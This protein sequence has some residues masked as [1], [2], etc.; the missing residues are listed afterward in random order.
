MDGLESNGYIR[1]IIYGKMSDRNYDGIHLRG[2]HAVRHVSYRTVQAIRNIAVEVK[3][4]DNKRKNAKN[5]DFHRSCPQAEHQRQKLLTNHRAAKSKSGDTVRNIEGQHTK[6][7]GQSQSSAQEVRY[8]DVVR[9]QY[10]YSVPT[11]IMFQNL[12]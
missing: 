3:S 12:N 4:K 9:G 8:S 11:Q 5:Y 7:S 6:S 2:K 1:Q 10:S